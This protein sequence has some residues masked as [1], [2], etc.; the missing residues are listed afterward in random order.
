[1]ATVTRV[2]SPEAWKE[3]QIKTLQA[4]GETNYKV[5]IAKPRKDP[6]AAGIAAEEKYGVETK[7]AI[8]E[9]RRKHALEKTDMATWYKYTSDIGAGRLVPGVVKRVAKVDAFIKTFQP[10]LVSHLS[11]IDALADV[12]DSDREQRMLENLR[13]LKALKGKA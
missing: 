9:E 10:M 3:R 4:V 11:S 1:M 13:G 6:I 12:T 2:L 5:G 7:K 8:D